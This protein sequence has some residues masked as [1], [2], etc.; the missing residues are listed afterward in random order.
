MTEAF[1]LNFYGSPAVQAIAGLRSDLAT[2][3]LR[4]GRDVARDAAEAR[5]IAELETRIE[6]GGLVEA[7][8]RALLYVGGGGALPMV[9]ER[10]FA[11]LR[12]LRQHHPASREINLIR[13]KEIVREQYLLLRHDEQRAL[14]AIPRLLPDDPAERE[15]AFGALRRAVEAA[16]DVPEAVKKRLANVAALL[17]IEAT[18]PA[19]SDDRTKEPD[20]GSNG[21]V[22]TKP[23][24]LPPNIPESSKAQ[25]GARPSRQVRQVA[26]D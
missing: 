14:A 24:S 18:K 4:V 21:A 13:F 8:V 19:V 26:A 16:G 25:I 20:I 10:I 11:M 6:Q 17:R 5:S 7:G 15:A 3:R 22:T 1:F 2:A 23:D 9:D 12:Q